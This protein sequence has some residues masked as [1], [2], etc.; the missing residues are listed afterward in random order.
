MGQRHRRGQLLLHPGTGSPFPRL[1]AFPVRRRPWDFMVFSALVPAGGSSPCPV[2]TDACWDATFCRRCI[3][4][5]CVAGGGSDDAALAPLPSLPGG[6]GTAS[7]MNMERAT[8]EFLGLR[9]LPPS[10]LATSLAELGAK[11]RVHGLSES[12]PAAP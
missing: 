12:P 5:L 4:S 2:E 7:S 8:R 6:W 9:P 3:A 11:P 1:A 10:M